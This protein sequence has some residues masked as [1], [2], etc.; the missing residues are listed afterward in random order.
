M[1]RTVTSFISTGSKHYAALLN[2][3]QGVF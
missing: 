2:D 3:F 1:R